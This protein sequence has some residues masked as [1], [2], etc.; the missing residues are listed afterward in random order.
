M[1]LVRKTEMKK[2]SEKSRIVFQTIGWPIGT[3]A[4]IP[5]PDVVEEM[6]HFAFK[7]RVGLLFLEQCLQRGVTLGPTALELHASLMERRNATDRVVA[8]LARR[9]DEVA[10][11]EWVLFKSIKPFASTPN[12]TDWFPFDM[13]R[14]GELVSHLISDG[15]FKW[16]EKAPRQTTLIEAGGDGITDTTKKG[17]IYYIDCYVAPSTDYFIYLDPR[18]MRGHTEYAEVSGYEVPVLKPHAELTAILFHNVFP[19][20]TYT[21]ES[22]YLIKR[23]FDLMEDRGSLEDFVD[24]CR[25]QKVEYAC[26][27]NLAVTRAIDDAQFG[28]AD[29]RIERALGALGHREL[30]IDGFD[31]LGAFPYE[32]PAKVFWRA[33]ASKQ[34]DRTSFLSTLNQGLHMLSPVFFADVVKIVWRRTVKGGVYEQN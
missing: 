20:K 14:H 13:R 1:S 34:R 28:I 3:G 15:G 11:N 21:I 5:S 17:G 32:F 4:V 12:D 10:K 8:K 19:E 24:M 26:A 2:D 30:S 6:T 23:Y 7:S 22:Y 9:L 27:A 18:R 29:P 16:M 25:Q 31:P 33:F